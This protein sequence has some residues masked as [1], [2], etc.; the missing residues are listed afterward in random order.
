M[1]ISVEVIKRRKYSAHVQYVEDGVLK[2]VIIPQK[3]ISKDCTVSRSILDIGISVDDQ[4]LT[5]VHN[6]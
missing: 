2:T 5:E 3:Y 4:N 6:E 1:N